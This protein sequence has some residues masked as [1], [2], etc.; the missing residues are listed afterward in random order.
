MGHAR[1]LS[2][3]EDSDKQLELYNRIIDEDL[4]V[5]TIEELVRDINL[6]AATG[7]DKDQKAGKVK[8]DESLSVEYNDLRE[9]LSKRFDTTIDFKRNN[10]GAGKIVISFRSDDDLQRILTLLDA[11]K[12]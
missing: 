11:R 8:K 5:R 9:H 1:A 10:K 12:A 3:M 7:D 6:P 4:S 2:G